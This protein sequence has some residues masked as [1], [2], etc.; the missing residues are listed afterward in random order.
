MMSIDSRLAVVETR[1]E[2]IVE[3]GKRRELAQMDMLDK[4]STLQDTIDDLNH[5]ISKYKGFVGGIIFV[6]GAV[7]AFL[8]KFGTLLWQKFHG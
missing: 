7:G 3:E 8:S 4:L 2:Q 1:I 6:V 5:T